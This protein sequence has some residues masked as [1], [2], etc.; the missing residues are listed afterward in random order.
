MEPLMRALLAA[1]LLSSAP[2]HAGIYKCMVDG[3]VT[4]L[5][6]PCPEGAAGTE[7]KI[8]PGYVPPPPP[9]SAEGTPPEK[10]APGN[11]PGNGDQI[12]RNIEIRKLKPK[13]NKLEKEKKELEKSHKE[14]LADI[15]VRIRAGEAADKKRMKLQREDEERAFSRER[16]RLEEEIKSM[17]KKIDELANPP[18]AKPE[19]MT[20]EPA[21]R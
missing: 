9:P 10:A 12:A 7:V 15:D 4:Y 18:A 20:A 3:A 16:E 8:D 6:Q 13:L 21:V 5:D 14:K 2:L 19:T 1:G 17:Q 11:P